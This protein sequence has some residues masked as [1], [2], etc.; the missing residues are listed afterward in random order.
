MRLTACLQEL[1]KKL[2]NASKCSQDSEFKSAEWTV[3]NK[4]A[5]TSDFS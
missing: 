3:Q 2:R 4:H 5:S 1:E